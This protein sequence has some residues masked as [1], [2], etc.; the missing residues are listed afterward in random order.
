M[1]SKPVSPKPR[2]LNVFRYKTFQIEK[3]QP[4]G[5]GS[6]GAV[7]KA[8]CD[9]L[10]C[11]AKVLH[12]TILDPNDP[13][14][15]KVMQRFKQE[16]MFL[17]KIRHPHIVQYLAM[18]VDPESRLPLLLMELLDESLT[19]MLERLQ[20][21]LAYYIQ[22]DICHDV[23]LAISYLHSND[24]IHRDL[25][26]NNVLIIAGRRAKVTDFGMSKLASAAPT[27]TPLTM[28]PGTLAYMPPEALREPPRYTKKLDCFSEG[29]IIIQVCTLL[30]PDPGPRTQ[31][32]R[33]TRSPTGAIEMPV[34]EPERRKN[35]IDLIDPS[36]PLLPIALLCLS[37]QEEERPS[38]EDVCLSLS[39]I[40]ESNRYKESVGRAHTDQQIH[41]NREFQSGHNISQL[42]EKI[43]DLKI[44]ETENNELIWKQNEEIRS[45]TIELREKDRLLQQKESKFQQELTSRERQVQKINC[46]LTEQGKVRAD[47]E[48]TNHSLRREVEKLQEQLRG[49]ERS[50]STEDDYEPVSPPILHPSKIIDSQL[51]D[52]HIYCSLIARETPEQAPRPPP[53]MPHETLEQAPRPPPRMPQ[54]TLEQAPRPPPRVPQETTEQAPRPPP[55]MPQ[56]TPEQAP[57]PPP[58]LPRPQKLTPPAREKVVLEWRDGGNAPYVM[59]RGGA[60]ENGNMA[61]FV[62]VNGEACSYNA[63][64]RRW[65]ELPKCQ[66]G[67]SSLVVIYG[68]LTTVGGCTLDT[69]SPQNKLLSRMG[70]R[71]WTEHFPPMPTR[72]WKTAAASTDRYL[73]VAGGKRNTS[74][75]LNTVEV[76][77]IKYAQWSTVSSLPH[78]FSEA[79]AAMCGNQLYMLGGFD[80]NGKT[81]SVLTCSLADLL[82]RK[83]QSQVWHRVADAPTTRTTCAAV[84]G[85]LLAVGGLDAQNRKTSAVYSYDPVTNS[86]ELISNMLTAQY[87]RLV[88][89]LPDLNEM[90]VVGGCTRFKMD[91]VDIAKV[92]VSK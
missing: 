77:N 46:E 85:Q 25:S 15:G 5:N 48:Q 59:E 84:H 88:A 89:V 38:S 8:K 61:Y 83:S 69:Y 45:I 26:S 20:Q 76:M 60:V 7:Y 67:Y 18:T 47:L 1:A 23:A 56:E 11:A 28:C 58:R 30:L 51:H 40:K 13:G 31:L 53:R 39:D 55:R 57:C 75:H 54:E 64:T 4:L 72:R 52:E 73:I 78:T 22:V 32:V 19:K 24:I 14:A 80:D 50:Q 87:D 74:S 29:V 82:R 12:Q 68:H 66:F 91:N 44:K 33:D 21:S 65:N 43:S 37:Y 10:P 34:L 27:M 42:E 35:H 81:K 41:D 3:S 70:D 92:T 16:C 17:E 36:H 63:S 2:Q 90:I 9:Q 6:Y 62:N 79:S 71:K 49:P 86:W